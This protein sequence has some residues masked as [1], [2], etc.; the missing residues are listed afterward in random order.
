[1]D[2]IIG[3][4]TATQDHYS[5]FHQLQGVGIAAGPVI[6]PQE[7]FEDP[8][9]QARGFFEEQTHPMIGGPY[10]YPGPV[11]DMS[12]TPLRIRQM[13]PILGADNEYVYKELMGY[14]DEEYQRFIEDKH[15]G[16][17][18]VELQAPEE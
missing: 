15:V 7:V 5:V 18:C 2:E 1:M 6:K 4:W 8:H 11:F 13:H 17:M 3:E 16:D 12:E 10:K 9:Y 14:S